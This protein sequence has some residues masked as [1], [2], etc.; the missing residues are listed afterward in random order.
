LNGKEFHIF[1]NCDL[2][3]SSTDPK[4]NRDLLL[5]QTN[6]PLN[7]ASVIISRQTIERK[8]VFTIWTPVIPCV[9]GR[10]GTDGRTDGWTDG[11]RKGAKTICLS[12]VGG[13]IIMTKKF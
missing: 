9:G 1:D 10:D 4:N 7:V 2:D 5:M 6:R 13:F 11:R 8:Q 12:Q 3:L